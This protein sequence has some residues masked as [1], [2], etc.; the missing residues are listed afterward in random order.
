MSTDDHGALLS[1][2]RLYRYRL[3]RRWE[4]AVSPVVWVMLN[5][6]FADESVNDRTLARCM[7]FARQNGHGGVI[8]VNLFAWRSAYPRD[9]IV[10]A[11][12]VGPDN[13]SH[14]V[15]ACGQSD[16]IVAGWGAHRLAVERAAA[17]CQLIRGAQRTLQCFGK[18]TGGHPRH[19]GRIPV[20]SCLGVF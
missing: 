19:P 11:D 3:W 4:P 9:L 18:T 2:D 6:S 1:A 15:W 8:L 13:D 20:S 7:N 5:P 16:T 14:I 12:P 17:V 10:A